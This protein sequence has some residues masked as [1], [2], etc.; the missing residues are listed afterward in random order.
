MK[1][2][3]FKSTAM[4][5]QPRSKFPTHTQPSGNNHH[6]SFPAAAGPPRWGAAA[7]TSVTEYT[8]DRR[9]IVQHG[10]RPASFLPVPVNRIPGVAYPPGMGSFLSSTHNPIRSNAPKCFRIANVPSDW[11]EVRLLD[12]LRKIDPFLEQNAELSLYP[13]C[14][15]NTK[16]ALLNLHACTAYFKH[17]KSKDFNYVN[18]EETLLVI[19]SH[20]FDLTPLNTPEGEIHAESVLPSVFAFA[21]R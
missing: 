9:R 10:T 6:K 4:S 16:T 12:A 18:F 3:T 5:R 19:D 14:C 13:A 21:R 15:G 7:F 1:L 17:L 2:Y 11:D 8:M 20:F